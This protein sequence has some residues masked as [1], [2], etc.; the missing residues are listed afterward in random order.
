MECKDVQARML[1]LLEETLQKG[2]RALVEEHLHGCV[3]C[4]SEVEDLRRASTAIRGSVPLTAPVAT[5]L[6][7]ARHARLMEAHA[8]HGKTIRLFTV[9]RLVAA[10]AVLVIAL[11]VW[12]LYRHM[13][14]L[15][16]PPSYPE[17]AQVSAPSVQGKVP[18]AVVSLEE[19]TA[20]DLREGHLRP[21]PL[22][23]PSGVPCAPGRL[24]YGSL[25]PIQS[26]EI[27]IPVENSYYDPEEPVYWW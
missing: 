18:F 6:T 1:D 12:S 17:I 8:K 4:R 5:Y 2:Q 25:I 9:R 3:S 20:A 26:R 27:L 15:L 14:S 13:S 10:A 16:V 19:G 22:P 24:D 23:T 11:S 7:P 21:C